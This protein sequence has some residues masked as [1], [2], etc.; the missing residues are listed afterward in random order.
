MPSRIPF[1][2]KPSSI[3]LSMLK[4]FLQ[5]KRGNRFSEKFV[6]LTNEAKRLRLE[7]K[8]KSCG[9]DVSFQ[10]PIQISQPECVSIGNS[11]AFASFVHIWGGGGVTIGNRVMIGSHTAIT[12][13]TH[14]YTQEIMYS[15][16]VTRPVVI[17]DDVWISAHAVIMPGVTIGKGSVVGA[18]C[19]VTHDVA[20]LAIVVGVPGRKINERN[21]NKA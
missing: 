2:L 18:G 5:S 12:S 20:P 13:I 21:I 7:A 15:T 11:V 14:D 4:I 16:V 17:E 1:A 3:F 8:L 19:V 6:F 9:N 10:F